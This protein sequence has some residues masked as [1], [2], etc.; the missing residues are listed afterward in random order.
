MYKEPQVAATRALWVPLAIASA[1]AM[2]GTSSGL[3]SE[4]PA[5]RPAATEAKAEALEE[6]VVTG[7][8]ISRRDLVADTPIATIDQS[9]LLAAGQPTLDRAIGELPQFSAAQGQAET[10]DV[11]GATGFSGGQAY[12]DLRGLGS[13]RS[14]VL[15]DGRRL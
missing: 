3:A 5:T 7:S 13:N 2:T 6:I 14:L 4:S 10:G 15:L 11:Q 1:L 8:L 9:S 12:G